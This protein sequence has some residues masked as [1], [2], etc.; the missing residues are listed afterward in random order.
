MTFNIICLGAEPKAWQTLLHE[1]GVTHVG[2]SYWSL[3]KRMSKAGVDL[4]DWGFESVQ[5]DSGGNAANRTPDALTAS[6]WADYADEYLRFALEHADQV[7]MVTEFDCLTLGE[8]WIKSQRGR[9]A[10]LGDKF[11]PVWHPEHGGIVSLNNLGNEYGRVAISGH[12]I[13]N[14]NGRSLSPHLNALARDGVELHGISMTKPTVLRNVH[15]TTASSTSWL[16]PRM[17]GDTIVWVG[18]DLKRYPKSMK[19]QGRARHEALFTAAGFDAEKIAADDADEITR[20]ALWSWKQQEEAIRAS[21]GEQSNSHPL[22]TE[23]AVTS[24]TVGAVGKDVVASADA[25]V[26]LIPLQQRAESEMKPF[27]VFN[28]VDQET[29]DPVTQEVTL[30]PLLEVRGTSSRRCDSCIISAKCPEFKENSTCA[31]SMPVVVRTKEQKRA[32]VDGLMAMQ[33]Q[34]VQFMR[35]TEELNGSYADPNLSLEVDRL[36][37]IMSTQAELEDGRDFFKVSIEGRSTPGGGVLSQLFGANNAERTKPPMRV[38]DAVET[39][40]VI[41]RLE[42][43]KRVV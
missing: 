19:T 41:E 27:P 35:L 25:Q 33:A 24:D 34:R 12:D 11:C 37:K 7:S 28:T 4:T 17:F 29:V 14:D 38:L 36:M 3:R 5:L 30:T 31:Y 10:L 9:Y 42:Q 18:N 32:L 22:P 21:W 8:D 43:G 26:V 39:D 23:T 40:T 6:G 1:A 16:S 13:G 20:L 2:T 15:F